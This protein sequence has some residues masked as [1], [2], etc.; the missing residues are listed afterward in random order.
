MLN[1]LPEGLI[2]LDQNSKSKFCNKSLSD[3]L[4]ENDTANVN[5]LS[6]SIRYNLVENISKENLIL[7]TDITLAYCD[8]RLRSSL[9][10][11]S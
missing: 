2:I 1:S 10:L 8:E 4:V 6:K 9:C 5:D 7:F 11:I 3:I